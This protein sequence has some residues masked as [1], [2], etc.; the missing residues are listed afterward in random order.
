MF[1]LGGKKTLV[2]GLA[3]TGVAT[4]LFC[5]KHGAIVTAVD[6]RPSPNLRTPPQNSAK[7]KFLSG[8]VATPTKF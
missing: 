2:I 8:S 3:R 7:Q 6:T 4:S 1:E 5:A